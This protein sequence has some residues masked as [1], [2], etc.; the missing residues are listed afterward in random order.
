MLTINIVS[1]L[2]LNLFVKKIDA[3]FLLVTYDISPDSSTVW[4]R[5]KWQ[6]KLQYQH[7]SI[8]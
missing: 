8:I 6:E 5:A 7:K 2:H 4:I 3:K 1:F